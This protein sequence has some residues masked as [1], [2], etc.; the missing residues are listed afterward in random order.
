MIL[1]S[2]PQN[3]AVLS[4]VGQ[5][6]EFRIR[7]S[8]KAFSILSSGLYANKIRAIIRELSCN[9]LDSHIAAGNVGTPFDLHLPNSLEAW[10]S[11]RDYGTGL[12]HDQVT[13]IYTTYFES[14]KTDSNEFIGA[15]G[16]GSKSPFS[17]TD[18]FTV[19]AIKD[20]RRGVYTAFINEHGVPS[21]ALMMEERSTEPSGVEVKF[22]VSNRN[23]F[24][25]FQTEARHVFKH[26]KHRPVV[27]GQS[28][29]KFADPEYRDANLIPGV[30]RRV[31]SYSDTGSFAIMG[32]IAYPIDALP[33][34]EDKIQ[35]AANCL[36]RFGLV[37]EFENGELDFQASREGLS[38]IPSTIAAIQ[39]KLLK[40]NAQLATH[41]AAEYNKLTTKWEQLVYLSTTSHEEFWAPAVAEFVRN[42]KLESNFPDIGR[43]N[44]M[45]PV[46]Y[47]L[48]ADKLAQTRN[49]TIQAF[50]ANHSMVRMLKPATEPYV[51]APRV[52]VEFWKI[53][54]SEHAKFVVVDCKGS[55]RPRA[56]YHWRNDPGTQRKD[57]IVYVLTP[58]DK[59]K[60]MDLK[61]FFKSIANPPASQVFPLSS[62]SEKP[63]RT[64]AKNRIMVVEPVE[65]RG[66]RYDNSVNW[67]KPID[68]EDVNEPN[69][70]YYYVPLNGHEF[71]NHAS[72]DLEKFN[73]NL[74]A[75][76]IFTET[77][78][79]VRGKYMKDVLAMK[80][81]VNLDDHIV[82]KLKAG[83][84][85]SQM[86]LVKNSLSE[87]L[88]T[89]YRDA[90]VMKLVDETS[91]YFMIWKQF[92]NVKATPVSEL[93]QWRSLYN[94][95]GMTMNGEDKVRQLT[96][97]IEPKINALIAKYPMLKH[98]N[99]YSNAPAT[100]I[101]AYINMVEAFTKKTGNVDL[102]KS[103]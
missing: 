5:I 83:A 76:G 35:T 103:V 88:T 68:M 72:R 58:T 101:A 73:R 16:L 46:A 15:L 71:A 78:Y 75:T 49:I 57:H 44:S 26:F 53:V 10:F 63:K 12:T 90:G 48:H 42:N 60:P 96:D 89:L 59:T 67:S 45:T 17:Y 82:Q 20:G 54:P 92:Q 39:N 86:G 98:I 66:R 79:G 93:E 41:V 62:L 34:T 36:L 19:I 18:N 69:K 55:A 97:A 40:L 70:T 85:L 77:Y 1:N 56:V 91:E 29:F 7:N 33:A 24:G 21:I 94:I 47:T 8:A 13:N 80:N 9:A 38:Y 28:M 84:G 81:W 31:T 50:N 14:T 4:N 95:F 102:T 23:D 30:H 99:N 87:K 52:A 2:T 25:Q 61:G 64:A 3:Q 11:I 74:K 65:S 6:G 27:S 32:N 100:T 43:Y 51:Q 22:A 37:M